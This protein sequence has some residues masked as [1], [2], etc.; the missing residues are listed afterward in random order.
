VIFS[1]LIFAAAVLLVADRAHAGCAQPVST[2][3]KP[4]ATDCLY[5]LR[6]AVG[7]EDCDACICD[8]DASGGIVATDALTCLRSAV[9]QEG[10]LACEACEGSTHKDDFL[11]EPPIVQ[12]TPTTPAGGAETIVH[13]EV[14]D[15]SE[16]ALSFAGDGCGGFTNIVT[17]ANTIELT[18]NAGG[19]GICMVR[20]SATIGSE[21]IDYFASFEVVPVALSLPAVAV[22]GGIFVPGEIPDPVGD[23]PEIA[24]IVA[25]GSI[26]NGGVAEIRLKLADPSEA[27]NVTQV[28]VQVPDDAGFQGHFV[29]PAEVDGDEIVVKI[30]LDREIGQEEA[31]FAKRSSWILQALEDGD[32]IDFIFALID[33]AGNIS[34]ALIKQ[35]IL[36][37]VSTADVQI[38]LSW[39]TISD[40]D[41]HL[42]EPGGEEIYFGNVQS[43]AGGVLDLDSNAFCEGGVNNEN[44]TYPGVKPPSGE[45]TVRVDFYS[46]CEDSPAHY[47]LTRTVCG[48]T[49][50]FTGSFAPGDEDFGGA[51]SGRE[52]TKFTVD[53]DYRVRGVAAYEDYPLTVGGLSD[54][55]RMLPIR[56]AQVEVHR[57]SDDAVLGKGSTT[58]DGAFDIS[59]KNTGPPGYFVLVKAKQDDE[60][61]KQQVETAAGEIYSVKS[62]QVNETVNPNKQELLIPA[63]KAAGGPG[64]AF[65]IFDVGIDGATAAKRA[66]GKTPPM[67][68]WIWNDGAKGLCGS[69]AS[70]Y[71]KKQRKLS[72]LSLPEDPDEYDDLVLLHEYGHFFIA[73]YSRSDSPGGDHSANERS[74]P[75]LAWSEGA[76][77]FFGNTAK[78]T[79][80]YL[81]TAAGGVVAVRRDIDLLPSAIPLGTEDDTQLGKVSEALVT[82][83]L[84]DLADT[85]DELFDSV[86]REP[87]VFAALQYLQSPAFHDRGLAGADLVDFLDGWFC[88]GLGE[89]GDA[90]S[91]V[92]ANVATLHEF[93]YDFVG[94]P[95]CR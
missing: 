58:Q 16:I 75:L 20:A 21:L 88:K 67:L 50:F 32:L 80:I 30:Q 65:N 29:V 66:V 68:R 55:P 22:L 26:I 2:G 79:N 42:V 45:Y 12:V 91:G 52:I 24:E 49:D 14:A 27:A 81:D 47:T 92:E 46:N 31:T 60:R 62:E 94:V 11:A 6:A 78:R 73:T 57:A 4:T 85:T 1:F 54:T 74:N 89:R 95:S 69:K 83:V 34:P 9:G 72:V 43:S 28:L 8:A 44:I 40:L 59:F 39:D 33:N 63:F 10:K 76:A 17:P 38:S 82:A 56:F 37:L 87:G 77:T 3:D 13:V 90:F 70:C 7:V 84:W 61:F 23:A 41:L 64:Q 53:C 71:S 93:N 86:H 19:F 36:A 35:L 18:N 25:P 48:D 51:G 5:V 15:A